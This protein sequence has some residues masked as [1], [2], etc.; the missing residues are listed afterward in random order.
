MF[1]QGRNVKEFGLVPF[2]PGRV[3]IDE[4]YNK[5][6]LNTSNF[7]KGLPSWLSSKE[8]ACQWRKH[9]ICG[10]NPWIKRSLGVENGNMFQYSWLENSMDRA[11][12]WATVH[13]VTKSRIQ[14]S[15]WAD[16]HTKLHKGH[17]LH[18]A[19]DRP[20]MWGLLAWGILCWQH[21]QLVWSEFRACR[22]CRPGTD[23]ATSLSAMGGCLSGENL[24]F[25]WVDQL[26]LR[27][28]QSLLCR[29]PILPGFYVV[30]PEPGR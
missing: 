14:L 1:I 27:N 3:P 25:R 23:Q 30:L 20:A 13:G 6:F 16:A 17:S 22:P 12:W 15:D 18:L 11:A 26:I 2:P 8:S 28:V 29:W 10:F 7:I 5:N 9:K 19:P 4:W 21:G 24:T